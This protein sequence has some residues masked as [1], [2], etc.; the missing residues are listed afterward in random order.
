[1]D[2]KRW[3]SSSFPT[4][5]VTILRYIRLPYVMARDWYLIK[6]QPLLHKRALARLKKK[7]G[8]INVVFFAIYASVWKYDALY[9]LLEADSRF[10]PIVL[11]CPAVN[12]GKEHMLESLNACYGLFK[13]KGYNVI[14]SYDATT[15]TYVDARSLNPDIIFYTNPYKGL[16][17]DR[18]YL[19]R[20][21]D[22]LTCFVNY[23]YNTSNFKFGC[24]MPFHNMVWS[25]FCEEDRIK[26][27]T[28]SF[29]PLTKAR[30]CLVTGYPMY[31][32]FLNNDI[33]DCSNWKILDDRFKRVI[34]A[35]HHTIEEPTEGMIKFSS[36]LKY[37]DQMVEYAIK[38]KDQIQFV[39]KP[40]P[41]LKVKL[42]NTKGWGKERTDSYYEWWEHSESTSYVNGEYEDLFKTSDALIHDCGSFTVE[43]LYTRKPAMYL[44]EFDHCSQLN[45][46]GI[47]AYNCHYIASEAKDIETFLQHVVVDGIDIL[48]QKRDAFYDQV[49]TPP[50]GRTASENIYAYL[51]S[52]IF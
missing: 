47:E 39:F 25:M 30:N 32:Q 42:Y 26:Q 31:E 11:V 29:S 7:E 45:D 52:Q 43:Y 13:Q 12:R 41:L 24:A 38:Y 16:I 22:V 14:C 15:N 1:M 50:N 10:N 34:W 33:G 40:H 4:P 44:S 6:T 48:K 17:E 51:K 8:P 18:Y 28:A 20:F 21:R 3:V 46:V 19:T 49:L 9:K 36:F 27:M 5:V 2:I 23:A 35:P 37:A